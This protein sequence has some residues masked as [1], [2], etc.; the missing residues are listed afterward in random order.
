LGNDSN[1]ILALIDWRLVVGD[2]GARSAE[3]KKQE[4]QPQGRGCG[5]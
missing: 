2:R 5:H 4:R 1:L 3:L